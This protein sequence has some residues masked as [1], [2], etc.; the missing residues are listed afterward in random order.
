VLPKEIEALRGVDVASASA[1]EK[2]ALALTYTGDVYSWGDARYGWLALGHGAPSGGDAAGK[3]RRRVPRR[4]EALRGVRV[5]CTAAGR[6][7]S[8][9]VTDKGEVYTWGYGRSGALGH[10]DFRDEPLPKRIEM[11]LNRGSLRWAWLPVAI[12]RWWR[13]RTGLFGASVG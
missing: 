1:G 6:D 11:L 3:L 8:C 13:V 10:M 5:R 7:H 12:T 4:I 2:H 9:A